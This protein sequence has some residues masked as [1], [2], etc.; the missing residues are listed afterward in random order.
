MKPEDIQWNIYSNAV[1]GATHHVTGWHIPSGLTAK[2]SHKSQHKAKIE[3]LRLLEL[4]LEK[5]G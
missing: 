2:A 3:V 1:A 5:D 4:E